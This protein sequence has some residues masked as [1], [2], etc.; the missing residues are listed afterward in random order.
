MRKLEVMMFGAVGQR[1]KMKNKKSYMKMTGKENKE[2][3]L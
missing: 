3:E 1:G 2:I